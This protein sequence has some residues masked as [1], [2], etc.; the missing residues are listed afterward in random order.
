MQLNVLTTDGATTT[1]QQQDELS[2]T[3]GWD[4]VWHPSED[5]PEDCEC[6]QSHV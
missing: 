2:K 3:C 6:N 1:I 5:S 4:G